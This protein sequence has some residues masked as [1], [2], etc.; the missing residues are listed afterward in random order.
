MYSSVNLEQKKATQNLVKLNLVS[1]GDLEHYLKCC[2]TEQ[3]YL[4]EGTIATAAPLK[5]LNL[6]REREIIHLPV[7]VIFR[8][9]QGTLCHQFRPKCQQGIAGLLLPLF[10]MFCWKIEFWACGAINI[11]L[12]CIP[13]LLIVSLNWKLIGSL[14]MEKAGIPLTCFLVTPVTNELLISCLPFDEYHDRPIAFLR[15]WLCSRRYVC[16]KIPNR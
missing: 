2:N 13:F 7:S 14:V 12:S 9:W 11:Q 16:C 4:L 15:E 5:D 8:L 3:R 1:P 10:K 6:S